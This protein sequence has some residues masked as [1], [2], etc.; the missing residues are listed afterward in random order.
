[1]REDEKVAD[2]EHR[3]LTQF[4]V[5]KIKRNGKRHVQEATIFDDRFVSKH[6]KVLL[7]CTEN[8]FTNQMMRCFGFRI[9][10]GYGSR[11]VREHLCVSKYHLAGKR[12]DTED[13]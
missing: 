11:R 2:A 9:S 7:L 13:T 8:V 4:R 5:L 1:M 12:K 6:E 10:I 3:N